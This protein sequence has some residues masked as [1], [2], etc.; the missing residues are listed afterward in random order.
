MKK[1]VKS[2]KVYLSLYNNYFKIIYLIIQTLKQSHTALSLARRGRGRGR[3]GDAGDCTILQGSKS[4]ASCS[5]N[6]ASD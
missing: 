4:L 6:S 1:I 5:G 3:H 2:S